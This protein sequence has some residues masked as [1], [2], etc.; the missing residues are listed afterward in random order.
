MSD[1]LHQF[2]AA[3]LV[4]GLGTRLR[5]FVG[6]RQKV[7]TTVAGQPF[8]ARLLDYFADAGLRR[9]VLCTGYQAEEVVCAIGRQY[10]AMSIEYSAEPAPLGTAGALRH[11]LPLLESD[12]VLAC[13]GDSYCEV[14][15]RALARSHVE[16][17]ATGSLVVVELPDT[18]A[19]GRVTIDERGAITRFVEKAASGGPGWISAGVYL[20]NRALLES[21]PTGRTVSIERETFPAWVGHGLF[22]FPSRGRFLDIGT[23]ESYASAEG[24]FQ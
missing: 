20:L 5:P 8:L 7:L 4:G 10:R 17:R 15:L 16:R 6:E 21:I 19:S 12:P 22:A 24:F 2:T 11:A 18:R 14:D 9:V 1:R 23:P 13:N 3:I